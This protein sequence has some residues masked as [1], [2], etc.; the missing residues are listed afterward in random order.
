MVCERAYKLARINTTISS[1]E[2]IANSRKVYLISFIIWVSKE[3]S[4]YQTIQD[5]LRGNPY[6]KNQQDALYTFNL[7][8]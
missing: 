1:E 8:Q 3:L 2:N 4:V 7:F 6:N 5:D